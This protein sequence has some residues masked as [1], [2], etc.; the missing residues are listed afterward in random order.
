MSSDHSVCYKTEQ[1]LFNERDQNGH[2]HSPSSDRVLSTN[3][4]QTH[5]LCP[6]NVILCGHRT[7]GPKHRAYVP[8]I[9]LSL[10]PE[11]FKMCLFPSHTLGWLSLKKK[12][13]QESGNDRW[14]ELLVGMKDGA[15]PLG[16]TGCGSSKCRQRVTVGPSNNFIVRWVKLIYAYKNLSPEFTAKL[17]TIAKKGK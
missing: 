17:L 8:S 9:H 10:L 3:G 4:H 11:S 7:E 13:N 12:A 14:C 15:A 5:S 6:E 2:P 1:A 16:K